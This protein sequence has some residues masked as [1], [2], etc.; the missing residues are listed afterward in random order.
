MPGE[1][2]AQNRAVPSANGPLAL[3]GWQSDHLAL[4]CALAAYLGWVLWAGLSQTALGYT[5]GVD[6]ISGFVPEAKRFLAGEPLLSSYH[7]PLYPMLLGGV[8]LLTGDWVLAARLLSFAGG[9]GV[10]VA[11]FAL[12]RG[13]YGRPG[14]LGALLGLA[15]APGFLAYAVTPSS[16]VLF[17]AV[18]LGACGCAV[19]AVRRRREDLCAAAGLLIGCA[20]LLRTNGMTLFLLVALPL[21][22]EGPWRARLRQAAVMGF[23]S[24]LPIAAMLAFTKATGSS[25][26]PV[27]TV[28][29]LAMTLYVDGPD[30]GSGDAIRQVQGRFRSVPEVLLHDPVRVVTVYARDL[31]DLLM[32]HL[33]RLLSP[34]L[35]FLFAPGL[36]WLVLRRS[37]RLAL[38]ALAVLLAQVALLNLK[39]FDVRYYGF[40]LPILG[41]GAAA[42]LALLLP[43]RNDAAARARPAGPVMALAAV[44][45]LVAFLVAGRAAIADLAALSRE[46]AELIAREVP[47]RVPPGAAVLARKPHL[48]FYAGASHT[49]ISANDLGALRAELAGLG[50][51]GPV[52]LFVGEAEAQFRPGLAELRT[53]GLA[54]SWLTPVEWSGPPDQPAKQW[55]LYRFQG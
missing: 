9:A 50:A 5:T 42:T 13:L 15:A 7:P 29:N 35:T 10:L 4:L 26:K 33:P 47:G 18:F 31:S 44:L 21:L 32:N 41:A 48:A 6:F 36:I 19:A 2:T 8:F 11:G 12:C 54:P 24:L 34:P 55:V 20:V 25:I 51:G 53:P 52:F 43:G 37:D 49:T 46:P 30:R 17:A 40:L 16:D 38:G 1:T 23:F 28:D 14:G 22:G 27:G 45:S 3:T 39:E